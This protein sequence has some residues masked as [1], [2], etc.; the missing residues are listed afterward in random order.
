MAK[1]QRLKGGTESWAS[2]EER[3]TKA[4]RDL[5]AGQAMRSGR[6]APGELPVICRLKPH[7]RALCRLRVASDV[8]A[9]L[10]AC[11]RQ[12]A[13]PPST[14]GPFGP[15][16]SPAPAPAASALPSDARHGRGTPP[17][18]RGAGSTREH[19][20]R[21]LACT[22]QETAT[23][24]PRC[25]PTTYHEAESPASRMP[26]GKALMAQAREGLV[27]LEHPRARRRYS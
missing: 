21:R 24:R 26:C 18:S 8:A 11:T 3:Q 5:R 2:D 23:V 1:W 10:A 9:L 25:D 12:L 4:M 6:W 19:A 13:R 22:L 27:P 15:S 20:A 7:R 17:Y 14:L 16:S